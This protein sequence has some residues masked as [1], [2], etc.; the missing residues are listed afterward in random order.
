MQEVGEHIEFT[1]DKLLN[2]LG[3]QKHFKTTSPFPWIEEIYK[4]AE[5]ERKLQEVNVNVKL[6][7]KDKNFTLDEDFWGLP[8]IYLVDLRILL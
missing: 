5:K 7:S 4:Q 6:S 8:L 1:V 3:L 2:K